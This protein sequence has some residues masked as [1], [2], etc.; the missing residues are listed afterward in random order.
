MIDEKTWVKPLFETLEFL[1]NAEIAVWPAST[2]RD[3]TTTADILAALDHPELCHER[4]HFRRRVLAACR[5]LAE[6]LWY[7]SSTTRAGIPSA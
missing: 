6:Q 5:L 3:T 7:S 1:V 4:F 2:D